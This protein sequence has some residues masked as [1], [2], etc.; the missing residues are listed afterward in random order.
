MKKKITVISCVIFVAAMMMFAQPAMSGKWADTPIGLDLQILSTTVLEQEL[1]V[2]DEVLVRRVVLLI[3]G[4]NFFNGDQP[5]VKLAG[6]PGEFQ[7][8]GNFP[9]QQHEGEDIW[10]MIVIC[11]VPIITEIISE[12]FPPLTLTSSNLLLTVQTGSS[13]LQFD[14]FNIMLPDITPSVEP[15]NAS[16]FSLLFQ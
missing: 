1:V 15:P 4:Y 16:D 6:T 11:T 10:G 12:M 5:I 7:G 9:T 14:T 8:G 2:E 13:V 3:V